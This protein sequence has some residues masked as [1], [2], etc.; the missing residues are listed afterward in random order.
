[1]N[2][3]L[4][5]HIRTGVPILIGYL[6]ALLADYGVDVDGPAAAAAITAGVA[7]LYY[8]VVRFAAVKFPAVGILL[9]VNKA[10]GYS[11]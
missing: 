8:A 3:Y 10:P 1:M 2:D 5:G 6:V 9:G 4:I 11:D 7:G